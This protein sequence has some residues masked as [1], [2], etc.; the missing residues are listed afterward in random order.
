M[1]GAQFHL[2]LLVEIQIHWVLFKNV[3]TLNKMEAIS[4][5]NTALLN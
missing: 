2:D 4:K 5:R 3:L 1:L